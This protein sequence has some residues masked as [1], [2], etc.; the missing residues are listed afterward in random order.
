MYKDLLF[1]TEYNDITAGFTLA[2]KDGPVRRAEMAEELEASGRCL[3]WPR[4]CHSSV[5]AA[6]K[7]A[8]VRPGILEI[9]ETDGI[10]T[11]VPGVRLTSSHG[12]CLPIYMYDPCKRVIGLAHSGWKGCLSAIGVNMIRC[13]EDEYGCDPADVVTYIGPGIGLCCFEVD[14]DV[15]DAFSDAFPWAEEDYIIRKNGGKY[16]IDLKGI[17]CEY[18]KYE[19]IDN[20][21]IDPACTCCGGDSFY[22][23]RRN[24]TGLRHMAYM[25][26]K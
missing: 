11:N 3:V 17:V 16:M 8:D 6:V 7:A 18:L 13:M 5:V 23:Y 21:T 22:S 14:R 19:G 25:E 24:R 15:E 9:P 4:Q 20:I 12:D 10:V 26:I 1:L 2:E